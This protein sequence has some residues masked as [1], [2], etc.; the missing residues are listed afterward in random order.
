M[1]G[2]DGVTGKWRRAEIGAAQAEMGTHADSGL[3]RGRAA[4]VPQFGR[5]L[6]KSDEVPS[7]SRQTFQ[8]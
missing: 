2:L 8:F 5:P 3:H 1:D 6:V 4:R 7:Q